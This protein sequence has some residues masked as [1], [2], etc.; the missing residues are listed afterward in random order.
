MDAAD[1][2]AGLLTVRQVA[3]TLHI[4][5]KAV[6]QRVELRGVPVI[7]VAG[8]LLIRTEYMATL[9]ELHG[10]VAPPRPC[11]LTAMAVATLRLLA[12]WQEAT[13]DE[14]AVGLERHAGNVRKYLIILRHHGLAEPTGDAGGAPTWLV[15]QAGHEHLAADVRTEAAA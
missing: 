14:L 15:T 5:A 13:A 12:D 1:P 6:R 4:P 2:L 3:E 10:P 8:R 9:A 11:R 7:R